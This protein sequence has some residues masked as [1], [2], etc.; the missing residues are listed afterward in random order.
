MKN[1]NGLFSALLVPF[2]AKGNLNEDALRRVARHNI[3]SMK[4]DGLY[5][6]GSTGE[7]FMLPTSE[8]KRIFKAVKEEVKDGAALIAQVGS[9]DINEA[10]DLA[11]YA[12]SLGYDAVSSVA[13]FYY[14]FDFQEIRDYYFAL[15]NACGNR[16]IIYS[17]PVLSGVNI[18]LPQFG[19][20]FAN[21]KIAG[22]KYTNADLFLLERLRKAYPEKV[23]YA[24]FDELL[25]S[26]SVLGVSGAIGSTYNITA[27]Y[28]RGILDAV[29]D[30]DIMK[31]RG[32][33]TVL[34][35]IIS[36]LLDN[37]LYQTLKLVLAHK[38]VID[39]SYSF[40]RE[41]M[42]KLSPARASR[43]RE[44]AEKYEL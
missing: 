30:G 33:Q 26:T 43:A 27:K 2:D 35:D 19:E 18:S 8:K 16:M 36:D 34:N 25:L 32:I 29:H 9:L 41:P 22:V 31:A 7:N 15:T 14:K 21:D 20:L 3:D 28:A 12:T 6:G 13:P 11:E 40:C 10:K 37:G 38:G 42:K 23:V 39:E 5:V 4:V 1:L 24:G 17:I 44:I